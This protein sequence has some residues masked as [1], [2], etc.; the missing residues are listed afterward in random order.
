[1]SA[2]QACFPIATMARVLGASKAGFYAWLRRPPS[3]HAVADAALLERIKAV[4][5]A[6]RQTYGSPRVHAALRAD[7]ETHSR[8]RIE[9]LMREAGLVGASQRRGGPVTTRRDGD[10]RPAPDLVDRT[11]WTGPGGPDLVDQTWWTGTSPPPARTSSGSPTSRSSRP[12]AGSCIWPWCWTP[13]AAS[14]TRSVSLRSWAGP[15]RTTCAPSWCWMCW[16]WPWASATARRHSPQR[17]GQPIYLRG[18]RNA[19]QG[20]QGPAVHGI[21]GRRV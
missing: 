6:S 12:Q 3:A 21:G 5:A 7:G 15:W 4:H 2:N 1:M 10:A 11:W 16:R 13:G 20:S 17:P 14:Q 8:K 18:V 19:L 9:R